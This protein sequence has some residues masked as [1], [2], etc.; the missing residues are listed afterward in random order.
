MHLAGRNPK[1]LTRLPD[2]P[3]EQ[4]RRVMGMLPVECPPQVVV[5]QYLRGD[6]GTQQVLHRLGREELRDQIQPVFAKAEPVQ[7]HRHCRGAHTHLLLAGTCQPIEILRQS[8]L[9]ANARHDAQ[10][11]QTLD[12]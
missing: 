10:M 2:N 5:V 12:R 9:A 7:N 3:R 6:A 8:D 11:I 4:R 1:A